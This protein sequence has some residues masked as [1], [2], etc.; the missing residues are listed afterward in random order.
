MRIKRA[1][2][3]LGHKIASIAVWLLGVG[4]IL[5]IWGGVWLVYLYRN[6]PEGEAILFLATG[7][8][9][10]GLDLSLIGF[11]AGFIGR[12][13]REPFSHEGDHADRVAVATPDCDDN[14]PA[15]H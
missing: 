8:L 2:N 9:L 7:I 6:P 3:D 11:S 10:S 4:V 1:T 15:R 14:A 12:A 13:A 5:A